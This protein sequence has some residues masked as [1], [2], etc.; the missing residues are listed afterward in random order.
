MAA[1]TV[2]RT[3]IQTVIPDRHPGLD[4]GAALSPR[5]ARWGPHHGIHE[6]GAEEL[7]QAVVMDAESSSA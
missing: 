5:T 6:H 2:I 3:V 4:D 7:S 1:G